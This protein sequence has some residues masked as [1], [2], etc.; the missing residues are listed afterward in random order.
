MLAFFSRYL[1]ACAGDSWFASGGWYLHSL[2]TE[3]YFSFEAGGLEGWSL[4]KQ[5][6]VSA[7]EPNPAHVLPFM[8]ACSFLGS[9]DRLFLFLIPFPSHQSWWPVKCLIFT[10]LLFFSFFFFF[11][12]PCDH[13]SVIFFLSFFFFLNIP[14]TNLLYF[15]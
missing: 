7:L 11:S 9:A 6:F 12:S 2:K 1:A 4:G 14:S 3:C 5:F 15:L 8:Y 10:F 13:F